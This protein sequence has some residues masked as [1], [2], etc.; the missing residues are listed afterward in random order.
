MVESL[1]EL[2]AG[3]GWSHMGL[4]G[5]VAWIAFL[6][7]RAGVARGKCGWPGPSYNRGRRW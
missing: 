2:L 1:Q 7:Y 4:A 5:I 3:V 6:T